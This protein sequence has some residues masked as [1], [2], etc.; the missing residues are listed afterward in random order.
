MNLSLEGL[1]AFSLQRA[2]LNPVRPIR[3][4]LQAGR[5]ERFQVYLFASDLY[6][7]WSRQAVIDS[8]RRAAHPIT[9]TE[10]CGHDPRGHEQP[11]HSRQNTIRCLET[12][13]PIQMYVLFALA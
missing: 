8:H 5:S 11:R 3:I 9:K 10:Y 2:S 4:H 1:D 12:C 7:K 13:P 6:Q